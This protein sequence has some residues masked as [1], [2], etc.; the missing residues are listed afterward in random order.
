MF[1][2]NS[3]VFYRVGYN[4]HTSPIQPYTNY[5]AVRGKPKD[6]K[7]KH[8]VITPYQINKNLTP[9]PAK[10]CNPRMIRMT[11]KLASMLKILPINVN[12]KLLRYKMKESQ[13]KHI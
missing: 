3:R 8:A 10:N 11:E 1:T 6:F 13:Q 5:F 7:Y 4:Q 12:G 2:I 9:H